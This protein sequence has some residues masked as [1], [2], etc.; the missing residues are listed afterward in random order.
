MLTAA[1]IAASDA[2]LSPRRC[3]TRGETAECLA[4]LRK[5]V[6]FGWADM[7]CLN[8]DPAFAELRES[9]EIRQ[10][11][12]EAATKVALPPPV[13]SGGLPDLT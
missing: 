8:H 4:A 12:A 11:G 10:L 2:D 3:A 6:D 5:A 9:A 1:D 13:G 7:N